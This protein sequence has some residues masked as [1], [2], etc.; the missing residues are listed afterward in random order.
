[1]ATRNPNDSPLE[2]RVAALEQLLQNNPLR[3][4][5]VERGM[6]E[7][8]DKSM[9]LIRDS[10]LRV[11]GIAYVEGRLEGEG[12]LSWSG[13]ALLD[14]PVEITDTLQVLAATTIEGLMRLLS[15]LQ[16]E[17]KIT[18]G[19][20]TIE[21]GAG[22]G[23]IGFGDGRSINASTGFLGIYDGE[24]FVVFNS[25]GVTIYAGGSRITVGAA[26]IELVGVKTIRQAD[27]PGSFPGAA[28]IDTGGMLRRVVAAT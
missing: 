11:V 21:P 14:G 23:Q 8:Y 27:V 6:L 5:S 19:N 3:A 4:A 1:M 28:V 17:G 18:A 25:S 16:V 9:L 12:T 10:N 7:F 20:L 26:G 2:A 22:G 24:R 13:P 15:E